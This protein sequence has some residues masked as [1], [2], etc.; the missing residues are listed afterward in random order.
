MRTDV[1]RPERQLVLRRKKRTSSW[2]SLL[3]RVGLAV[4]AMLLAGLGSVLLGLTG[5]SLGPLVGALAGLAV[6]VVVFV[7]VL[8]RRAHP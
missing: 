2:A 1:P 4:V 5:W 8:R 3:W 7:L 6:G